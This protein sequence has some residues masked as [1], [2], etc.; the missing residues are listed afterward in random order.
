MVS[1]C[2]KCVTGNF[3]RVCGFENIELVDAYLF[4]FSEWGD[5]EVDDDGIHGK[6]GEFYVIHNGETFELEIEE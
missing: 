2:N 6:S 1:T 4:H 5:E 3:G